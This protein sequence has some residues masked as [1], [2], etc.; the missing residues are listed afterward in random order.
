MGN[1]VGVISAVPTG[2]R[3]IPLVWNRKKSAGSEKKLFK[4][5]PLFANSDDVAFHA[6]KVLSNV[7]LEKHPNATLIFHLVDTPEGSFTVLHKLFKALNL[8]AGISGIT[9]YSDE[10]PPKGDLKK[11]YIPFNNSCHFDY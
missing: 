9:L 1:I 3:G 7:M 10:Y 6:M 11:V 5:A 4:I 8:T 2:H